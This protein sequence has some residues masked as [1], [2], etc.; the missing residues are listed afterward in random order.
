MGGDVSK[1]RELAQKA[2]PGP[3]HFVPE[4]VG[5]VFDDGYC[6]LHGQPGAGGWEQNL[7]V[8]VGCS[9]RVE[10]ELGA[11]VPEANA[12]F[13]AACSPERIL[14]YEDCVEALM[15]VRLELGQLAPA[16]FVSSAGN[17]RTEKAYYAAHNA[18]IAL[19]ALEALEGP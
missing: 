9:V 17:E 4:N 15:V 6:L 19:A 18:L 2:T 11:G 7:F 14:A 1:M 3:W 10:R 12:A 16:H 5:M 13:I 8:W